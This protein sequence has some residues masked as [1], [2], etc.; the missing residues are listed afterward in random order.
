MTGT[1]PRAAPAYPHAPADR[2]RA[3]RGPSGEWGSATVFVVFLALALM[4]GAGLVID[5]GYALAHRRASMNHAE[6]AA[7]AAADEVSDASLRNGT[8]AVDPAVARVAAAGY[9]GRVAAT[10]TVQ[11]RGDRVTVTVRRT[12]RPVLLSL[13]GIDSIDVTASATAVSVDETTTP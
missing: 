5:G 11:V 9:L 6:Q 7:R 3:R 8:P 12:Y 4:S 1:H 13:V 2:H 10:G